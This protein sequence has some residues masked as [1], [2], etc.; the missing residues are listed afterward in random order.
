MQMGQNCK[1]IDNNKL[2][3]KSLPNSPLLGGTLGVGAGLTAGARSGFAMRKR[4]KCQYNR[5]KSE[6]DNELTSPLCPC[7]CLWL[8]WRRR[9]LS[10]SRWPSY[11]LRHRPR[12]SF[13]LLMYNTPA[14]FSLRWCFFDSGRRLR[15]WCFNG[16][17]N[18][19]TS[20][21]HRRIADMIRRTGGFHSG[22]NS[23]FGLNLDRTAIS[24]A[25]SLQN[26]GDMSAFP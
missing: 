12:L 26:I 21:C 15:G 7:R 2:I 9:R 8:W 16:L 23:P 13:R 14:R 6:S 24:S 25:I 1:Y 17:Y 20:V 5:R 18:Q 3:Y 19:T 11:C 22:W 4:E 10:S